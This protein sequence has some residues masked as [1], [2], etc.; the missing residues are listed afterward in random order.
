MTSQAVSVTHSVL[1][2]IENLDN[3]VV[4]RKT[5]CP[6]GV[7]P[8]V[9]QLHWHE[10]ESMLSPFLPEAP[11]AGNEWGHGEEDPALFN[12]TTFDANAIVA[13]LKTGGDET[14]YPYL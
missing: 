10:I 4:R 6:Y 14:P 3:E 7:L 13:A 9:R 1:R 11:S 8:Y 5:P 2:E 12:P